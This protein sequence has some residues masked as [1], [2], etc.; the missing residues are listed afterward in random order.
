[1]CVCIQLHAYFKSYTNILGRG[2]RKWLIAD[3]K[4]NIN[5]TIIYLEMV[6]VLYE[7]LKV[8]LFEQIMEWCHMLRTD[9]TSLFFK[10]LFTIPVHHF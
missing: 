1:M 8:F 5:V 10:S 2:G 9:F 7:K 4:N 3:L 6:L